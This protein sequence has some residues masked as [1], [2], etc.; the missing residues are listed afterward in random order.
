MSILLSNVSEIGV[1][2][3]EFCIFRRKYFD[4]RNF[5]V[6]QLSDDSPKNFWQLFPAASPSPTDCGLRGLAVSSCDVYA[7]HCSCWTMTRRPP[8]KILEDAVASLLYGH[9]PCPVR[10]PT[11]VRTTPRCLR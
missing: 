9:P 1:F 4:K 5:D 11:T 3:P 7:S 6:V 10:P 8:C 2:S